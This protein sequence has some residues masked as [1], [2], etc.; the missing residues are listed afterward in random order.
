MGEHDEWIDG[1]D[2]LSQTGCNIF[3]DVYVCNHYFG[4]GGDLLPTP[5][6]HVGEGGL[7]DGVF[8]YYHAYDAILLVILWMVR[9][10]LPVNSWRCLLKGRLPE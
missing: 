3:D 6:L 8:G 5:T 2:D 9:E 1:Y 4:F 10:D 7:A